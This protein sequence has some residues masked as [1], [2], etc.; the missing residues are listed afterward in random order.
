MPSDEERA[1]LIDFAQA[2][3]ESKSLSAEQSLRHEAVISEVCHVLLNQKEFAF[4]Q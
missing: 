4:L 1:A 2:V 3:A